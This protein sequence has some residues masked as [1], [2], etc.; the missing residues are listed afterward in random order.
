VVNQRLRTDVRFVG[1]AYVQPR[2]DDLGD[3]RTL[4]DLSLLFAL[5]DEVDLAVRWQWRH[6]T[7][8][9][10][11]VEPDDFKFTSGFTVALR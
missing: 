11:G 4:T 10:G 3:A 7:R 9:P 5:T 8:P 1:V 2:Y 6:D